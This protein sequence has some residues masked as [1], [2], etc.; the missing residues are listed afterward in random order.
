MHFKTILAV[1]LT[2][3]L[4][5]QTPAQVQSPKVR[6]LFLGLDAVPYE[7]VA[8]L[9]DPAL[10]DKALFQA[11]RG[12]AAL[13]STFPSTTSLAFA[14]ILEGVGLEKSPGYEAKFFDWQERRVRGGGLI[15]YQRIKFPWR[16]FWDW[17]LP[18]LWAK[19]TSGARPVKV[20]YR[21]IERSL[22][23]FAASDEDPFF[24]YYTTTDLVSHLKSPPGLEPVL[25]RLDEALGELRRERPDMPFRTVIFSDHGMAGGEPLKNVRKASLK[26]LR[27]A[28]YKPSKKLR[29]DKQV[30]FA[31][32]GLVSSFVAFTL[33]E[34][35][36]R[37]ARILGRVEG[38]HVCAA[39]ESDTSWRVEGHD[40]SA[41]IRRSMGDGGEELF[42]YEPLEGDPLRLADIVERLGKSGADGFFSDQKWLD[43]T[44]DHEYPDP[45]YRIVRGFDLVENPASVICGTLPGYMYGALTTALV[46]RLTVG[47][48]RWTH[49]G[50]DRA[51]TLGFLMSDVEGWEVPAGPVRFNEA[52]LPFVEK[53]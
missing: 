52:L 9:S 2:S 15:S 33:P 3:V 8:R 31:P 35:R 45:L 5:S 20:C 13:I 11:Q 7:T 40:G 28:G 44:R 25:R 34:E 53:K 39:P 30:A 48:L 21:S 38:V 4:A 46:S 27:A 29:H 49:G 50:I 51:P 26:A 22:E 10:G 32:Y 24:I 36:L 1:L 23:A 42:A 17:K 18:G 12:P 19:L 47:R 14:G 37:V 6:T 41:R 16:Q 43:A